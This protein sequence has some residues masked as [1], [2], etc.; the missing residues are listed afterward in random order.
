M[1][2][3]CRAEW[4]RVGLQFIEIEMDRRGVCERRAKVTRPDHDLYGMPVAA[5][6]DAQVAK[7]T[8]GTFARPEQLLPLSES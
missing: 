4:F 7:R 3:V 2:Q 5:A 8:V 6:D 1:K